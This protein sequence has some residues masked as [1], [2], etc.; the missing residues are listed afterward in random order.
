V[1]GITITQ[2]APRGRWKPVLLSGLVFPGLGQLVA[3]HPWR[4]LFFSGSSVALLVAVVVRVM[5]ETQ[6]LMPEEADELLD[7]AL[8]FRLAVEVHRANA[9]FFLWA[10]VGIVALWLGSMLDAWLSSRGAPLE[11]GD[12]GSADGGADPSGDGRMTPSG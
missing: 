8:P 9:S 5:R 2:A 3:G 1:R 4:A 10:T 11:S 7:P 6:R 12:E